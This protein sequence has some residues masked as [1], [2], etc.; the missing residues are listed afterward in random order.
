ME[1]H[2]NVESEL[3]ALQ[4]VVSCKVDK[5][6]MRRCRAILQGIEDHATFHQKVSDHMAVTK[7]KLNSLD[8][9]L[10]GTEERLDNHD[11]DLNQQSQYLNRKVDL[12]RF[13]E[14]VKSAE[15][16]QNQLEQKAPLQETKK[17]QDKASKTQKDL[18]DKTSTLEEQLSGLEEQYKQ[19]SQTVTKRPT[20]E[21]LEKRIHESDF[22]QFRQRIEDSLRLCAHQ[23]DCDRIERLLQQQGKFW[24]YISTIP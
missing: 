19:V 20:F 21:D 17:F 12:Q 7:Q 16:V 13:S 11:S 15:S 1:S 14:L 4:G 6:E 8:D 23:N 18:L 9:R 10:S 5:S 22:D 24:S 3:S 2:Q